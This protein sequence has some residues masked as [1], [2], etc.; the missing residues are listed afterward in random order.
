MFFTC[1]KGVTRHLV[2]VKPE[3]LDFCMFDDNNNACILLLAMEW[4]TILSLWITLSVWFHI[5]CFTEMP[6]MATYHI[7]AHDFAYKSPLLHLYI[8]HLPCK[9]VKELYSGS[10]VNFLQTC[11]SITRLIGLRI[12]I[13]ERKEILHPVPIWMSNNGTKNVRV[14]SGWS[15]LLN[16]LA[17]LKSSL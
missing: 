7:V 1:C 12:P 9:L 5:D 16:F 15:F 17:A 8:V 13:V 10:Y 14:V 6:R 2:N 4:N 3:L 11:L